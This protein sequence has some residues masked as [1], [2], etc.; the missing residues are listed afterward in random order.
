MSDLFLLFLESLFIKKGI[1]YTLNNL[2]KFHSQVK[3]LT[4]RATYIVYADVL[5]LSLFII[6]Y[7]C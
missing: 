6:V 5:C 1:N 2:Y 7:Y 3:L 4:A